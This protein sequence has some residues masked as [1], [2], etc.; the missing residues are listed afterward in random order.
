MKRILWVLLPVVVVAAGC[1]SLAQKRY[2]KEL[3]GA[4]RAIGA[5]QV[6]EAYSRLQAANKAA[7]AGHLDATPI[8]LL[9]AELRLVQGNSAEARD[10]AE[11]VLAQ[12][13]RNPQANELVAKV[14]LKQGAFD[15]AEQHLVTAQL[16]YGTL[17]ERQR[18]EDLLNLTRGLRA[19]SQGDTLAARK[20]WATIENT[21]LRDAVEGST[22]GQ[23]ARG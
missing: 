21:Q 11:T 8:Q 12:N 3:L 4:Q 19:Y 13:Q 20:Y 15:E 14:L 6:G 23:S 2:T 17:G 5:G 7:A 18:V 10:I 1:A 9:V 16:E 22:S